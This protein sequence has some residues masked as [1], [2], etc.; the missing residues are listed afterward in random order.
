MSLKN[1]ASRGPHHAFDGENEM[2]KKLQ[3]KTDLQC[4]SAHDSHQVSGSIVN[5]K[6]SAIMTERN[7]IKCIETPVI[8][9]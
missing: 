8:V 2:Q 9:C 6:H 3:I 1:V 5:P 4:V 7:R